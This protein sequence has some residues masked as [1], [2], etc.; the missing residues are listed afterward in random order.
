MAA[1]GVVTRPTFRLIG[2]SGPEAV[3]PL[4]KMA[5]LGGGGVNVGL[6]VNV[7]GGSAGDYPA[8]KAAIMAEVARSL[9]ESQVFRTAIKRNARRGL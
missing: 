7:N 6:T 3:V 8:M 2:E 5:Q 9:D 4:H 1:G